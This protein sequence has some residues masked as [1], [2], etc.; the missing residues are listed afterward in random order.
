MK[1]FLRS[2]DKNEVFIML[3][4]G[5]VAEYNPFHNGHRYHLKKSMEITDATH[6]IAVMSGAFTQRAEP[7]LLTKRARAEAALCGGADL[8][9]ELPA[10]YSAATAEIFADRAVQMLWATGLVEVLSFG[11]EYGGIDLLWEAARALETP[12]VHAAIAE[13]LRTGISYA[14]ARQR[15]A[16][17]ILGEDAAVLALPNNL[18]GVEY[19]RAVLRHSL[20]L[21]AVTVARRGAGHHSDRAQSGFA[22]AGHIRRLAARGVAGISAFMPADSARILKRE[23]AAGRAMTDTEPLERAMLAKLRLTGREVFAGLFDTAEGLENRFYDGVHRALSLAEL[24]AFV[25]SKRYALSRIRR[26][27]LHAFL[28]ITAEDVRTEPPYL[29]VL[30][31]NERGR[32]LLALMRRQSRLPILTR[33]AGLRGLSQTARRVFDMETAACD[34]RGLFCPAPQPFGLDFK[35]NPLYTKK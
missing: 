9:I 4:M 21:S 30:A 8:V 11:S 32:A 15:A 20:P 23:L 5:I 14:A 26:M 19:L 27:A 28:G 16:Q 12:L 34:V 1:V 2:T 7:A 33:A 35:A 13:E 18:L 31:F 17:R 22:S 29:R 10:P 3:V 25:K 24:C 6:C